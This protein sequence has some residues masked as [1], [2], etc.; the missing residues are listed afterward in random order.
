MQS[1]TIIEPVFGL[2]LKHKKS[3]QNICVFVV[4]A[5]T[6]I[7]EFTNKTIH[8][9]LKTLRKETGGTAYKS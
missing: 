1:F 3:R 4:F 6:I 8:Q 9:L 2:G 5:M 7:C